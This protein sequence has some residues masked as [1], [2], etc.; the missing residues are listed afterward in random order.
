MIA[1]RP[2]LVAVLVVVFFSFSPNVHAACDQIIRF[3]EEEL[4]VYVY[5]PDFPAGNPV[6]FRAAL[7][8]IFDQLPESDAEYFV[9]FMASVSP[10]YSQSPNC[11]DD[12]AVYFV[13]EYYT[14]N[15]E[16]VLWPGIPSKRERIEL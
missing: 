16:I 5:C 11:V 9:S 6:K 1:M 15:D 7:K 4:R 10:R 14:H 13:A 2:K 8:A 12:C 3:D